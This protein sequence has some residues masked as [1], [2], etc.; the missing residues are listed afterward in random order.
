M[1]RKQL[2]QILLIA[3]CLLVSLASHSLQA[4]TLKARVINVDSGEQIQIKTTDGRF[5]Q[6]KLAGIQ[7]PNHSKIWLANA[8]R[9]LAMLLAGRMVTVDYQKLTAKGV[10]LGVV[11]HGGADVALQMLKAGLAHVSDGDQLKPQTLKLYLNYQSQARN[12][13][14]GLWRQY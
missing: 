12:K 3:I 4:A 1:R 8:R 7:I 11:R 2:H 9:H 5:R 6:V 14:L 13:G 10:I